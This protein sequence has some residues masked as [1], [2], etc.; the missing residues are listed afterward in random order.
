MQDQE[1]ALT[2]FISVLLIS[3]FIGQFICCCVFLRS[4]S[5][6]VQEYL[7]EAAEVEKRNN[8][9]Y[10]HAADPDVD[11]EKEE[12]KEEEEEEEYNGDEE[13]ANRMIR[14]K[15]SHSLLYYTVVKD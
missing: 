4:H 2:I 13:S 3:T 1:I 5:N 15:S 6:F 9:T 14:S 11:T 10:D 8:T 7:D 12:G